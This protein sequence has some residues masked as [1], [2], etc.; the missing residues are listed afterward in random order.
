MISHLKQI[1]RNIA[2]AAGMAL[3]VTALI[4][5]GGPSELGAQEDWAAK[6]LVFSV[7]YPDELA[8]TR[9]RKAFDPEEATRMLAETGRLT[10]AGRTP[11]RAQLALFIVG[12]HGA[13]ERVVSRP[14]TLE[15]REGEDGE[16]ATLECAL[17]KCTAD[18]RELFAQAGEFFPDGYFFP[19]SIFF[20][21]T[22]F[23]EKRFPDS[24]FS[25][26]FFPDDYFEKAG[27]ERGQVGVMVVVAPADEEM[28]REA[29]LSSAIIIFDSEEPR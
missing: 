18:A 5:A 3:A 12:E 11:V 4:A 24:I 16:F 28:Q 6:E 23:D 7:S 2:A 15:P 17:A 14:F 13:S 20:P 10:F 26:D 8:A 19:D 9:V 21:D 25:G 29:N 27:L 22:L 1:T